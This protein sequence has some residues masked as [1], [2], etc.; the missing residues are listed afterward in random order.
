[1]TKKIILWMGL[2]GT[3][4]LFLGFVLNSSSCFHDTSCKEIANLLGPIFDN[5]FVT[6]IMI[7][8]FFT[9]PFFTLFLLTYRMRDEA[10]RAWW[11]PARWWIPII[12]LATLITS[13]I[14]SQS[15]SSIGDFP[16]SPFVLGVLYFLFVSSSLWRI[17]RTNRKQ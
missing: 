1:M 12:M 14:D 6:V 11:N 2:A 13:A 8:F 5:I 17:V 10:F 3:L 7:G 15:G 9:S 16:I 4:F